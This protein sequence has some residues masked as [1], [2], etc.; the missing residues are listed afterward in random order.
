VAK[1]EYLKI[2]LFLKGWL[3]IHLITDWLDDFGQLKV[4]IILFN[5][6]FDTIQ[7]YPT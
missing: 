6:Y 4:F 1:K 5:S 7:L 3:K 2:M